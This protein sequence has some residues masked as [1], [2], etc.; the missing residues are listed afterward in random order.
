[1]VDVAH[2]LFGVLS[3]MLRQTIQGHPE[4]P[5]DPCCG[6]MPAQAEVV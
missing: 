5:G 1:M 3:G 6:E 2:G 4:N